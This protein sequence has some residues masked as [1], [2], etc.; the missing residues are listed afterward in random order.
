MHRS[1]LGGI[2]IDCHESVDLSMAAQ[3][4][5][6][7]LG[8]PVRDRPDLDPTKFIDLDVP[9]NDPHISIQRVSHE[10]RCHL[11]LETDDYELETQRLIELGAKVVTIKPDWAVFEAPTGHRFCIV[12]IGR[13]NFT[14]QAHLWEKTCGCGHEASSSEPAEDGRT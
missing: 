10:S 14:E 3:F 9:P 11:D 5:S 4:W 7:V 12:K 8:Y 6:Q 13:K 2:V 1:Q